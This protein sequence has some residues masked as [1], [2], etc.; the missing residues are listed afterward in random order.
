MLEGGRRVVF[1]V[2]DVRAMDSSGAAMLSGLV[3]HARALDQRPVIVGLSGEAK[4]QFLSS[5]GE[6]SV[7]VSDE[8]ELAS[9]LGAPSADARLRTGVERYRVTQKPRYARLFGKLA[10]GQSPHTLFITCSDSRINPNL[11]TATEPGE[12]FLLRNIGN[13]VSPV[14]AAE[15]TAV[16]AAIEY[17]VAILKVSK[18]VVCGHSSCGAMAAMLSKTPLPAGLDHLHGWIEATQVRA[19]LRSMPSE[20]SVDELAKLNVLAQLDH[21]RT[22]PCVA[23]RVASGELTLSGWFFDVAS[24]EVEWWSSEA[25]RFLP[26]GEGRERPSFPQRSPSETP[27]PSRAPG[28]LPGKV[29]TT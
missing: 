23:E 27:R 5:G 21:V 10:A 15:G 26:V 22:Y 19:L 25:Q 28:Y 18:I 6:E 1:D 8:R 14:S 7:L 4:T 3:E 9:V 16:G 13:L 24:G 2:R 11:I 12:L 29:V 17:A 20:L